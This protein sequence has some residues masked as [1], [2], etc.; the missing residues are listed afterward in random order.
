MPPSMTT[1][2]PGLPETV[3][4]SPTVSWRLEVPT[5]SLGISAVGIWREMRGRQLGEVE[6][7]VGSSAEPEGQSAHGSSSFR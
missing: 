7:L 1:R 3:N 2:S 6:A 4:T 5:T